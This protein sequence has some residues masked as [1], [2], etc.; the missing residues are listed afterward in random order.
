MSS[1]CKSIQFLFETF[2]FCKLV[3]FTLRVQVRTKLCGPCY[4]KLYNR[5]GV[6]NLQASTIASTIGFVKHSQKLKIN[7][8]N[9]FEN[10]SHFVKAKT[11]RQRDRLNCVNFTNPS[12]L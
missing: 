2:Y 6:E 8:R 12:Y 3:S 1:P 11:C 4:P 9:T 5:L 10:S 7:P